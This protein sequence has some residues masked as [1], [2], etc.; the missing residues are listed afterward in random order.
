[1]F[2]LRSR[3]VIT[4][5]TPS[6]PEAS[7]EGRTV[8]APEAAAGCE[9]HRRSTVTPWSAPTALVV[10]SREVNSN[11]SRGSLT[12]CRRAAA[13]PSMMTQ[14]G[15]VR[16]GHNPASY[17][18]PSHQRPPPHRCA[19]SAAQSSSTPPRLGRLT[20]RAVAGVGGRCGGIGSGRAAELIQQRERESRAAAGV[21]ALAR[22]RAAARRPRGP[23]GESPQPIF[24]VSP[25]EIRSP[26][27]PPSPR[28]VAGGPRATPQPQLRQRRPW[29]PL[30]HSLPLSPSSELPSTVPSQG[31][32][33]ECATTASKP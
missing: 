17:C 19:P 25:Q 5:A 20:R 30:F 28:S 22:S 24:T 16:R 9:G 26:H 29:Y 3:A 10:H 21:D 2:A 6:P 18:R 33:T 32:W 31:R 15:P 8:A 14:S 23:C 27:P 1:M 4:S 7:T 12:A 13:T 11:R